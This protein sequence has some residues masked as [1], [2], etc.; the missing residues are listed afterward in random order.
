MA[1][2]DLERAALDQARAPATRAR[3]E[4]QMRAPTMPI[5]F[6]KLL[7][8]V[9]LVDGQDPQ[10]R[11]LLDH[12]AAEGFEV[13]VSE[14]FDRD[15]SEDAAVGAYIA[16][17]DVEERLEAAKKLVRDVRAVG[18]RTPLWAL[19]DSHRIADVAGCGEAARHV[20]D[21]SRIDVQERE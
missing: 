18:F 6:H 13:E 3:A 10:T 12:I 7:K 8:V 5:P 16:F 4:F 9:A 11:Q 20:G 21:E 19:A 17:I 15:V 14:R 2:A 1:T